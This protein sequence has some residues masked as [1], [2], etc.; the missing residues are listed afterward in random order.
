MASQLKQSHNPDDGKGLQKTRI[1]THA[2][3]YVRVKAQSGRKI[4]NIDRRLYELP[5]IRGDL[6]QI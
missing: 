2:L 1:F 5:Q 3:H 6:K 4:N